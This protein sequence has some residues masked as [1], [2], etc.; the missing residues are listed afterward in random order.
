[1]EKKKIIF[2]PLHTVRILNVT[3]L[4]TLNIIIIRKKN[5]NIILQTLDTRITYV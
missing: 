5:N 1:M 4:V 2:F 3:Q